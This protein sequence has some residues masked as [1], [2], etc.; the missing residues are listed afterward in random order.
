MAFERSFRHRSRKRNPYKPVISF[1][2]D[3]LLI[4]FLITTAALM[5]VFFHF[6]T[7]VIS[8]EIRYAIGFKQLSL[9]FGQP[10]NYEMSFAYYRAL[11]PLI[12][13]LSTRDIAVFLN[14]ISSI[15][16]I[17]ILIPLFFLLRSLLNSRI[18]FWVGLFLIFTPGYW[19]LSRYGHPAMLSMLFFMSSMM[20]FNKAISAKEKG[21]QIIPFCLAIVFALMAILMRADV[22]LWFTAPFGLAIYSSRK[23]TRVTLCFTLIF[24]LSSVC[25]YLIFKLFLFGDLIS[26]SGGTVLFHLQH[27]LPSLIVVAK[28]IMKNLVLFAFSLLPLCLVCL[29][30]SLIYLV[31]TKQWKILALIGLWGIPMLV[32]MPFLGMDFSRLSA[33]SLAPALLSIIYWIDKLVYN[34][35][36]KMLLPL[37]LLVISHASLFFIGPRIFT[38]YS[39]NVNFNNKP[40]SSVPIDFIFIDYHLRK[41]YLGAV[42]TEAHD[43]INETGRNIVIVTS[44]THYPWYAFELLYER[45]IENISLTGED[46]DTAIL[47]IQTPQNRFYFYLVTNWRIRSHELTNFLDLEEIKNTKVHLDSFLLSPP[48]TKL[49]YEHDE[50]DKLLRN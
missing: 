9:N 44:D 29:F 8:D 42:S 31:R 35:N 2:I 15:A 37:A 47:L 13:S 11:S 23:R 16:G 49:F 19:L 27:R 32:F 39:F 22:V 3:F 33:M 25:L 7:F 40:I 10:F 41:E 36:I 30:L 26:P 17:L 48:P 28:S 12:S 4:I 34:R 45:K 1:R 21:K 24:I 43:V 50:V 38:Y 46:D 6:S 5:Y 18:A 14:A 20:F